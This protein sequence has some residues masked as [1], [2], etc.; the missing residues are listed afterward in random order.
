[1]STANYATG[2][3]LLKIET[4]KGSFIKKISL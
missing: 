4:A 3:Y 2:I 1:M